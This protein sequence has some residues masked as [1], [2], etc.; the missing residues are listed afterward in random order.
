MCWNDVLSLPLS[1]GLCVGMLCLVL[2]SKRRSMCWNVMPCSYLEVQVRVLE[3]YVLSLP[4][5]ASPCVGMLYVLCLVL[6]CKCRSMCCNAMCYVL[7]LPLSAGPCVGMMSKSQSCPCSC[8]C[9]RDIPKLCFQWSL[10]VG[11]ILK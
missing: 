10:C 8:M 11:K 7:S 3:C 4:L 9:S 6:T 2:T 5:S 1:E